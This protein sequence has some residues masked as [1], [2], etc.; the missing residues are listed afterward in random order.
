MFRFVVKG[1]SGRASNETVVNLPWSMDI[2]IALAPV[3]VPYSPDC[4]DFFE[5]TAPRCPL[6]PECLCPTKRGQ[7]RIMFRFVVKRGSGRASNETI[8]NLA[9]SMDIEIALAPV[10]VPYSPDCIDFFEGTAPRCPLVPECLC[11]TKR[12]QKKRGDKAPDQCPGPART[13]D[14]WLHPPGACCVRS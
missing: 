4:I 5:G 8:V 3:P 14:F 13:M 11:P 12:G 9:G 1:G 2:E 6:V 7:F 10:P